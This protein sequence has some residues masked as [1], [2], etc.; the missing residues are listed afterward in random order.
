[1]NSPTKM[2]SLIGAGPGDPELITLKAVRVLRSANVILY[3][4]LVNE[5]LLEHANPNAVIKYVGKR[6]SQHSRTQAEINDLIV[7]SAYEYGH[8]ARLKGGDPFIFGRATEEIETAALHNIPVQI[9]PGISSALAVPASQMIPLT[10]RGTADSFWVTTGTTA[11][12]TLSPDL[13]LA[14][15]S[16][17]TVVILMGMQHLLPI[18]EL[19]TAHGKAHTPVAIIQQGTTPMEK[20]ATGHIY[21]IHEVAKAAGVGS[22]AI[23]VIGN[24]VDLP[25][26]F[27]HLATQQLSLHEEHYEI[28]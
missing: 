28:R 5:D 4:A 17:A 15:Q 14:A 21:N 26:H 6:C 8:V 12:G 9:I 7:S 13:E 27:S 24:V 19:F 10:S 25:M 11:G 3:D 20:V 16:S 1:M 22:P 23:I 18:I 2:L